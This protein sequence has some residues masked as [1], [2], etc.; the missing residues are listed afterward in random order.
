MAV[1]TVFYGEILDIEEDQVL[2]NCLIHEEPKYFETRYFSGNLFEN[3][4]PNE[5]FKITII[6]QAGLLTVTL[7]KVNEDLTEKFVKPDYF[8]D[9]KDCAFFIE[10]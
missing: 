4:Q 3:P 5:F 2:M 1:T 7:E 10:G 8:T 9:L 6:E